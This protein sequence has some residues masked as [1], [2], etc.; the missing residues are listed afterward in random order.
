MHE[1]LC[2]CLLSLCG[3]DVHEGFPVELT[4]A[5]LV[6]GLNGILSA[7]D[8]IDDLLESGSGVLRTKDLLDD[9]VDLSHRILLPGLSLL[10]LIT[11]LNR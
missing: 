8:V 11:L 3:G 1:L 7:G 5:V 10:E 6:R 2:E 9:R 4:V